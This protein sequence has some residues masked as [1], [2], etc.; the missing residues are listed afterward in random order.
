[1]AARVGRERV[2]GLFDERGDI[3]GEL[4]GVGCDGVACAVFDEAREQIDGKRQI[5]DA[6][7]NGLAFGFVAGHVFCAD[8]LAEQ[9]E[10][11][12]FG[13]EVQMQGWME[14]QKMQAGLAGGGENGS[15]AAGDER[16]GFFVLDV[17]ED[18]QAAFAGAGEFQF[19]HDLIDVAGEAEAELAGEIAGNGG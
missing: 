19:G 9:V 6:F 5:P 7:E 2:D 18:E 13:K 1:M 3:G 11:L 17:I 12:G 15:R 10:A 16:A 4:G 8:D 14:L